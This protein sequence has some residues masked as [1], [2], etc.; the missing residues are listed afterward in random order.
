MAAVDTNV[1]VRF[2][3]EDD[4]RQLSAATRLVRQAVA[5][6]ERLF[7]PATVVLELEWVLR[8]GFGFDKP[9]VIA[10]LSALLTAEGMR[11]ESE[12]AL[13][14]ALAAYA[15]GSA[16]YADGVHAAL[17]SLAGESPLWTFDRAA[18]RVAGARLLR[19]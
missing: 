7:V 3:V 8:S 9:T 5:R 19:T 17:A 12:S 15:Q 6:G 2:V 16:D 18:S 4:K 1:L 11:F 14:F 13:E 10:T